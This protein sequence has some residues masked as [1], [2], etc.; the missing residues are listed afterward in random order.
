MGYLEEWLYQREVDR[1]DLY[2][3]QQLSTMTVSKR[4]REE[5]VEAFYSTNVFSIADSTSFKIFME[6]ISPER[7]HVIRTL[8]LSTTMDAMTWKRRFADSYG[9]SVEEWCLDCRQT[10]QLRNVSQ[11]TIRLCDMDPNKFPPEKQHIL[12]SYR[13]KHMSRTLRAAFGTW[14]ELKSLSRVDVKICCEPRYVVP[15]QAA[16]GQPEMDDGELQEIGRG[17]AAEILRRDEQQG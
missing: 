14:K 17:F 4:L 16:T 13:A 8:E 11:I 5:A 2:F 12:R 15:V 3:D 1:R 10:D 6:R 9:R 7:A